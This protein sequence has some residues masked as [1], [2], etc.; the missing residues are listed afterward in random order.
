[1]LFLDLSYI[2]GWIESHFFNK[3]KVYLRSMSP[4]NDF[5]HCAVRKPL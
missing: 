3:L 4:L 2:F 1:M 5:C